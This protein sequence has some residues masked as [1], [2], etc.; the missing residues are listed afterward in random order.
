MTGCLQRLRVRKLLFLEFGAAT[1]DV[2]ACLARRCLIVLLLAAIGTAQPRPATPL[3]SDCN[4]APKEAISFASL[5]GHPFGSA[6]TKDG[7]HLFVSIPGKRTKVNGIAML[8][9][10]G[11]KVEMEKIFT[12]ED[13]PTQMILTHD[14]KL[15]IVAAFSAIVFLDVDK[16]IAREDK[17]VLGVIHEGEE[18]GSIAVDVT[19]DDR[20]LFV[21]EEQAE[22][23]TVIDLQQA[24]SQGFTN[25]AIVGRISVPPGPTAL[26]FSPEDKLLYSTSEIGPN[27]SGWPADCVPEGE[28]G[29]APTVPQGA[30]TVIDVKRAVSHPDKSVIATLPA[31]CSPVRIAISSDGRYVYVTARNSNAMLAFDAAKLATNSRESL[32]A[33][34]PVGPAPVPIAVTDAGRKILVGNSNRFAGGKSDTQ[35]ITIIDV[36]KLAQ[37][38]TAVLGTI[39]AGGFPRAFTQ[40]QDGRALFVSNFKTDSLEIIDVARIAEKLKNK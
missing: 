24:R 11:G 28:A 12:L 35:D 3:S 26:V 38:R 13:R 1:D 10:S 39:P 6:I 9:R 37:G 33:E 17:P 16:M 40:S 25:H 23:I 2:S 4:A 5:P 30:I 7:C 22:S 32:L 31:G 15:L 8:Q 29:G 19:G 18:A 27:Q 36:G 14:E 20:F 21:S 34:V